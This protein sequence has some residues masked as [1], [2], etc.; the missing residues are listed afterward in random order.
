MKR[1]TFKPQH[2]SPVLSGAKRY[3]SRWRDQKLQVGDL[4]SAVT[5]KP[6]KPA[7]LTPAADAFAKLRITSVDVKLWTD[8]TEQDAADC[9]VTRDWYLSENPNPGPGAR[10]WKYG[11]EVIG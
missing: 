1:L 4:V 8:F 6:G 7:F 3:T 5:G 10:I 11:F 2:Q 9:G